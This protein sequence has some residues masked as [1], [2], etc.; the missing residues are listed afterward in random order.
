MHSSDQRLLL[1]L[2]PGSKQN[3]HASFK[4]LIKKIQKAV[5]LLLKMWSLFSSLQPTPLV[6]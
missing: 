4:N 3:T 1:K 6:Y 5:F 2:H